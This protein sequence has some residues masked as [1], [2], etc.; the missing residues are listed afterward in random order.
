[1][2]EIELIRSKSS[3]F[4]DKIRSD[5]KCLNFIQIGCYDGTSYDDISNLILSECD[6]GLFIEPNPNVIDRL[7]ESKK[8]LV[9][10]TILTSA[11]V[12]NEKFMSNNSM[13]L[14]ING[15]NS[16]FIKFISEKNKGFNGY[17][18]FYPKLVLV[19]DLIKD[20]NKFSLDVL[21]IDCE[22]Y[23][24]DLVFEFLKYTSPKF[25]YFE[26]WNTDHVNM[27]GI[28][29]TLK[30]RNEIMDELKI[31]GYTFEFYSQS[32]NIIAYKEYGTNI[33]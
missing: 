7:I 24:H 27:Y 10:S 6:N 33:R 17:E 2:S 9:N 13:L 31:R 11:I 16:T 19:K 32:E 25:I 23:D 3:Y 8:H 28:D 29:V 26:S 18:W 15:G 21:L 22:G 5:K 20:F 30:T 12:P 14:D 4:I 1:M